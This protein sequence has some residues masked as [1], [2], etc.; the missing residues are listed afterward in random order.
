MFLSN[1]TK[2]LNHQGSDRRGS[3]LIEVLLS[4]VILST[5]L[6]LMIQSL[7]A[8]LRAIQYGSGYTMALIL[9]DNQMC[10][11]LRKGAVRSDLRE[12]KKM[13]GSV[14]SAPEY[15][16]SL[17]AEPSDIMPEEKINQVD[18]V[19]TWRSGKK[20]NEVGVTTLLLNAPNE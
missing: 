3:L 15:H 17:R 2:I 11:L 9:L 4:A 8:S 20:D 16:Y 13:T 1:R 6:T 5:A 7:T 19:I 10:E 12:T 14:E 18:A